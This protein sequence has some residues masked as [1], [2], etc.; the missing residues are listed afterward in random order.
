VR[1]PRV[2]GDG[3]D[4]PAALRLPRAGLVH[5]GKLVAGLARRAATRGARLFG[6]ARVTAVDGGRAGRPVRLAVEGGG[7]VIAGRAVIATAGYTHALG[8]LRGRVLPV[9]LQALATAPL[10]AEALAAL[11]WRWREGVVEARRLFSYF[12][13]TSDHRLVFGG[14]AP[15]YHFGGRPPPGDAEAALAA[16]RPRLDEILRAP[17]MPAPAPPISHVWTGVIGYTLDALPCIGRDPRRP[18]VIHAVGWCGH[19]L[20]LALASGAWVARLAGLPP[21]EPAPAA[22]RPGALAGGADLADLAWFRATPPAL[23]G[24]ALRWLSFRAAVG[25]LALLDRLA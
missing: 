12:R 6:G 15:R 7:E 3:D 8:L 2:P 4:G 22:A 20:A 18:A 19:G 16:L 21:D 13:L 1:L 24:E 5:P 17:G 11:G 25:A 23:P 9:H 10:S 14:A